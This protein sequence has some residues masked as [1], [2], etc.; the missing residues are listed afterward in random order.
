MSASPWAKP[1][2]RSETSSRGLDRREK[3][4]RL[5]TPIGSLGSGF[6]SEVFNFG[7]FFVAQAKFSAPHDAVRLTRATG[8]DNGG[9]HGRIPQCPRNRHFTGRTTVALA[10][11]S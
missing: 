6:L 10:K 5:R 7:H 3:V 4:I 8:A 11:F 9:R 2:S 1:A